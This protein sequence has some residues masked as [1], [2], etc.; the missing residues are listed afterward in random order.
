MT[1]WREA[2]APII[3]QVLKDYP[4]DGPEQRKALREAY[5]FGPRKYWPYKVWLD[6]VKRQRANRGLK[7]KQ[8]PLLE[9]GGSHHGKK[10]E[11]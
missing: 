8:L 1:G 10:P 5:P 3:S 4:Q 9:L 2:A 6:E 11:G 7:S